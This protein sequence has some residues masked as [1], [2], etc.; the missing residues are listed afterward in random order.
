[1]TSDPTVVVDLATKLGAFGALVWVGWRVSQWLPTYMQKQEVR[2]DTLIQTF[3]EESQAERESSDAR[4]KAERDA[5]AEQFNRL[6]E[7]GNDNRDAIIEEVRRVDRT[8]R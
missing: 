7:Q 2:Y 1:M 5:C 8:A 3:R 6:I 4:A